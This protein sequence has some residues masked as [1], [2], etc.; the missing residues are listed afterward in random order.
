MTR[1][2]TSSLGAVLIAACTK[3]APPASDEHAAHQAP[4][5]GEHAAH[6]MGAMPE[7][8]AP[9]A[10]DP[11]QAAAMGLTTEL[12]GERDFDRTVRTVGVVT[13][14]ETR[15]AHVH[16]RVRGWI[17]GFHVQYVGQRVTKGQPLVSLYSQDVYAAELELASLTKATSP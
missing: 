1:Y 11:A 17:E 10:I 12:V 8:F 3:H 7:G 6:D 9:V 2:F 16:S 13:V 4:A 15:T 14:D 5:A